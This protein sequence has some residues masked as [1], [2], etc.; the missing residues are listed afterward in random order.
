MSK[1]LS[2]VIT[3]LDLFGEKQAAL[4]RRRREWIYRQLQHLEESRPERPAKEFVGGE[5]FTSSARRTASAWS[6]TTTKSS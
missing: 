1:D 2:S 6:T 5:S 3:Q 4:D